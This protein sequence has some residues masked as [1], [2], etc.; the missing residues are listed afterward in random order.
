MKHAVDCVQFSGPQ[1]L[2]VPQLLRM[3]APQRALVPGLAGGSYDEC[4]ACEEL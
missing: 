3:R 4:G 2:G 1:L